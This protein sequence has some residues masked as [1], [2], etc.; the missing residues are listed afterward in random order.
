MNNNLD[1][2]L[3]INKVKNKKGIDTTEFKECEDRL[4]IKQY[5]GVNSDN[6]VIKKM[7]GKKL[8]FSFFKINGIYYVNINGDHII[9]YRRFINIQQIS[10]SKEG[11]HEILKVKNGYI[12]DITLYNCDPEI[13][14]KALDIMATYM[15][16]KNKGIV[17]DLIYFIFH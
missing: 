14:K 2:Y 17:N 7:D 5:S 4:I 3:L 16:N 6:F 8:S 9:D 11:D 13:F 10:K 1:G 15:K 12:G